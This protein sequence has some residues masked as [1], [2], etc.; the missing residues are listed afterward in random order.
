MNIVTVQQS[1]FGGTVQDARRYTSN[2]IN[3]ALIGLPFQITQE[4]RNQGVSAVNDLIDQKTQGK[5]HFQLFADE[6]ADVTYDSIYPLIIAQLNG[7]GG[8][9]RLDRQE[10]VN[11]NAVPVTVYTFDYDP[12][13]VEKP[14]ETPTPTD[15]PD[16]PFGDPTD[17]PSRSPREET[18]D[19]QRQPRPFTPLPQLPQLST[20]RVPV[21]PQLPREPGTPGDPRTDQ[22]DRRP[23]VPDIDVDRR[24]T[25]EDEPDEEDL[26]DIPEEDETEDETEDQT[27]E[28]AI[29]Q[30]EISSALEAI[31]REIEIQ[32]TEDRRAIA[33]IIG[34]VN[35]TLK[36][37]KDVMDSG[38]SGIE[39]AI[40][41][42]TEEVTSTLDEVIGSIGDTINATLRTLSDTT[43]VIIDTINTTIEDLT[44]PITDIPRQLKEGFKLLR[45]GIDGIVPEWAL[46]KVDNLL[47]TLDEIG[48]VGEGIF[49][50]GEGI[51]K[52]TVS[53]FEETFNPGDDELVASVCRW[54]NL[55]QR[56]RNECGFFKEAK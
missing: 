3:A 43:A 36:D 35:D 2:L 41:D 7:I 18:E 45:E 32:H 4:M 13:A 51:W 23:R 54:I 50:L 8:T 28:P 47:T 15:I 14:G 37:S 20:P 25:P 19:Q 17:K 21:E 26:P 40:R 52:T 9:L 55:M 27:D 33:G 1:P 29:Q 5:E 46:E 34:A 56:I 10:T 31:R 30:A 12:P 39:G 48:N 22:P 16:N 42:Q 38:M 11:D 53:S 6:I 44:S 24:D 49:N